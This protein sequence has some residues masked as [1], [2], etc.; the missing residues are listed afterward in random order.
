MNLTQLEYTIDLLWNDRLEPIQVKDKLAN[1]PKEQQ[2]FLQN[3]G[4]PKSEEIVHISTWNLTFEFDWS[5]TRFCCH[6]R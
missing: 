2:N 1:L 3:K 5:Q 4:L 6:L